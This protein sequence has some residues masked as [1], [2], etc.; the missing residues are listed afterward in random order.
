MPTSPFAQRSLASPFPSCR[1]LLLGAVLPLLLAACGKGESAPPAA[2]PPATVGV[3]TVTQGEVGLVTELPGRLEAS[4]VAQV[5]ARAAGILQ[6]RLFREGSD[7]KAGQ[8]LFSIDAA[9][10]AAAAASAKAG[11]ARAE[12]NLAQASALAARYKP[13]VEANAISKQEYANAVAAQ[14]Q[15]EADV[16]VGRA[17]VQT[18]NINLGYAAVSAPISGRIGRALVTEGALVGQGDATQLAVIQQINPM[19]VNFT[20]SASEVMKLRAAMDGGQFKRA[21][22]SDAASVRIVLEDGSEYAK[23]GRLLFSDLTVDATTGQI[24]LRAEVPNPNAQ[25]LPGL[26]VRVRLE[27][28]K[29]SNAITLPQQA[30]TRSAQGD[31]VMVVDSEGKVATRPVKIDSAKGNQWVVLEGLKTGE[32]VIVDG[33]QKLRPGASVKPVPWQAIGSAPAGGPAGAASAPAAAASA[34]AS[35]ASK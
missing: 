13:L 30:V 29:V 19:Y 14:K 8:P 4:R 28:A 34:P 31:T 1:V 26:Y 27:Q 33:F 35:A 17:N 15:A 16:A 32:Q 2:P 24:T 11:Q 12:A 21:G 25:L 22:G 7:V 3:V 5:R 18:A 6:K 20:Q 10:Y 23:P 9:P